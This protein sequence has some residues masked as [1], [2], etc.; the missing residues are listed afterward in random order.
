MDFNNAN[1]VLQSL[2]NVFTPRRLDGT[3]SMTE[4]IYIDTPA[5]VEL[6]DLKNLLKEGK[7]YVFC[8][9]YEGEIITI[10]RTSTGVTF[11]TKQITLYFDG[12]ELEAGQ[13]INSGNYILCNF[14]S[15]T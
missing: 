5:A 4:T 8:N 13:T 10:E 7:G 2:Q 14:L 12:S 3:V 1:G 15:I 9:A 6:T 11:Q